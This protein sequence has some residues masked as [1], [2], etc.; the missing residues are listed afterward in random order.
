MEEWV[1]LLAECRDVMERGPGV[2]AVSGITG[3]YIIVKVLARGRRRDW[4]LIPITWG[5]Q[6]RQEGAGRKGLRLQSSTHS[7]LRANGESSSQSH[8]VRNEPAFTSLSYLV[9]GWEQLWDSLT[10]VSTQWWIQVWGHPQDHVY[11]D[12]FTIMKMSAINLCGRLEYFRIGG[13][14]RWHFND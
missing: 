6:G 10:L 4:K 8:W 12:V 1:T 11:R 7:F 5:E 13:E 9:V 14:A 2:L 3:G